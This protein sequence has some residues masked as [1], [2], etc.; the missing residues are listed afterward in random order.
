M[1]FK[2]S[3]IFSEKWIKRLKGFLT[4]FTSSG[5]GSVATFLAT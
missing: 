4:S 5:R 2:E 1:R 3:N